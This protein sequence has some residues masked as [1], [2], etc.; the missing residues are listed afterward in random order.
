MAVTLG[1]GFPLQ[2]QRHR[3]NRSP[4]RAWSACSY[5]HGDEL[6]ILTYEVNDDPVILSLRELNAACGLQVHGGSC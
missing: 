1:P 2:R 3:S 5:D 4:V 6:F